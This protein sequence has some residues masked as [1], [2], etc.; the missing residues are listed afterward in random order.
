MPLLLI[1]PYNL[2]DQ[3]ALLKAMKDAHEETAGIVTQSKLVT[4]ISFN[5]PSALILKLM[6]ETKFCCLKKTCGNVDKSFC[7]KNILTLD[8]RDRSWL[9]SVFKIK[10]YRHLLQNIEHPL[11]DIKALS[12]KQNC[13]N[14]LDPIS[15]PPAHTSD[16]PNPILIVE[17]VVKI[18]SPS[19][20]C[21]KDADFV[22]AK[23]GEIYGLQQKSL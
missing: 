16:V 18:T 3:I 10:P 6:L 5:V 22:E 7:S 12:G 14:E 4:A 13:R 21:A 23:K 2:P 9:A 15:G 20:P 19:D 11:S 1:K 8:S 17:F